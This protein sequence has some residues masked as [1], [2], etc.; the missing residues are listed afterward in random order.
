[1]PTVERQSYQL[2]GDVMRLPEKAVRIGITVASDA[3]DTG[4]SPQTTL[5]AGL[6][7]AK[8]TSDG[9]YVPYGANFTEVTGEAVGTG[10]GTTVAFSLANAHVV[11]YS[12][13][14]YIDG[15]AQTRGVDYDI[16]YVKGTITFVTAP[17]TGAAV[18]ADY[19]YDGVRDG[20]EIPVGL[21]ADPVNLVDSDGN[22]KDTHGTLWIAGMPKENAIVVLNSKALNFAKHV[23]ATHSFW[24][25]T[26]PAVEV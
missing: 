4:N 23:L 17:G 12:E 22:I 9:K 10:D 18:T 1:M 7:M 8:R 14:V 3:R 11:P 26:D 15:V 25:L 2:F 21:L 24:G 19:L 13:T 6:V 5:R 20:S 16:D